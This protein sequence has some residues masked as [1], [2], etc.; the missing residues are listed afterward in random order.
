MNPGRLFAPTFSGSV[1]E[2]RSAY[3]ISGW[4]LVADIVCARILG[5]VDIDGRGNGS[6]EWLTRD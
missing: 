2:L 5:L 4:S 1:A 6:I 3:M